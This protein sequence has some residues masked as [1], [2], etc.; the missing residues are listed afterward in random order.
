MGGIGHSIVSRRARPLKIFF[1]GG[2]RPNPGRVEVAV[3]AQGA[4][5]F[6]DDMGNGTSTD[7]EWLALLMAMKLAHLLCEA[8][9]ELIG[10]SV[11]VIRQ[12][13]GVSRCRSQAALAHLAEY[14]RCAEAAQPRRLRWTPRNQNLAGIALSRRRG[15]S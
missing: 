3:V 10:D 8:D 1:D 12:A 2:C 9:C 14:Q 11:N 5:Y 4:V 7:A 15:L 6:F 13:S